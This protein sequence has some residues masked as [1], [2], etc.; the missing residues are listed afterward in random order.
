MKTFVAI[1]RLIAQVI[2]P[3]PFELELCRLKEPDAE[4]LMGKGSV[5]GTPVYFWNVDERTIRLYPT[6]DRD[7]KI[8]VRD[9]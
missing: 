1:L 2:D 3:K 9:N 4:G 8:V 7:L 5:R 6:P